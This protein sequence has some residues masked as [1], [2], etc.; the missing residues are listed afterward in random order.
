MK[1]IASAVLT[2][3]VMAGL[4][5]ARTLWRDRNIYATAGLAAGDVIVIEI[6]D[7]SSM[8]FTVDL[9]NKNYS[10]V[11]SNPDMIITGFLPKVMADKTVKSGDVTDFKE[12][13][14]LNFSMAGTVT[15]VQNGRYTLAG[16][17]TYSFNG[18]TTTIRV[19]GS[20]DP[21][22]LQG[23]SVD[24]RR[25]AD[26]R[27][28]IREAREGVQIRRDPLKE[29]ESANSALTEEEKQRIIID[30]LQKMLGELTR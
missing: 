4:C 10:T 11:S 3:I 9:S 23:R 25:V 13:G 1:K 21:E 20:V 2:V 15:G 16:T 26:F 12:S 14:K 17:R 6:R 22:I 30:Y 27:L 28:E 19:N 8:R 24:S 18:M 7:I 29:G 5:Q